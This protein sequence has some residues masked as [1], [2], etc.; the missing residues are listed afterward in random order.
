MRLPTSWDCGSISTTT[1]RCRATAGRAR[2]ALRA[3]WPQGREGFNSQTHDLF[4][5]E[6]RNLGRRP[7]RETV[8]VLLSGTA[9]PRG[10]ARGVDLLLADS[11]LG[12]SARR[13]P[14]SEV[15]TRLQECP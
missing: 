7:A 2:T 6:L 1:R 8:V 9:L 4:V 10:G 11:R 13:V 15:F 14:L 12:D 5:E 3:V